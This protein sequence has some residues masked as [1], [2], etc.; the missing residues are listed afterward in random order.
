MSNR[1]TRREYIY[2]L[3]VG[4]ATLAA[5]NRDGRHDKAIALLTD[6]RRQALDRISADDPYWFY[7]NR[8]PFR[9]CLCYHEQMPVVIVQGWAEVNALFTRWTK[10]HPGAGMIAQKWLDKMLVLRPLDTQKP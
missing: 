6:L 7:R 8:M 5:V 2:G 3:D 9:V 4:I 10:T 1:E